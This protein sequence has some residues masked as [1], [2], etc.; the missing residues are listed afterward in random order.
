MPSSDRSQAMAVFFRKTILRVL[1]TCW[2][3]HGSTM[4]ISWW[5]VDLPISDG[6]RNHS[7]PK[8]YFFFSRFRW[9]FLLVS[10]AES[11]S[12]G[13]RAATATALATRARGRWRIRNGSTL[14]AS[15]RAR[16]AASPPAARISGTN[17][18]KELFLGHAKWCA[19]PARRNLRLQCPRPKKSVWPGWNMAMPISRQIEL[20]GSE[21]FSAAPPVSKHEVTRSDRRCHPEKPPLESQNWSTLPFS[22]QIMC[23]CLRIPGGSCRC[24]NGPLPVMNSLLNIESPTIQNHFNRVKNRHVLTGK[25]H[26]FGSFWGSLQFGETCFFLMG[27]PLGFTWFRV[28]LTLRRP[29]RSCQLRA[30]RELRV[31]P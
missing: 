26:H 29:A 3:Q 30:D 25:A 2:A 15:F 4:N 8:P 17:W 27:N 24:S 13:G 20:D 12:L 19:L 11:P 22:R 6:K 10:R 28:F 31:G 14:N 5:D 21:H 7:C 16:A 9:A 18:T 23:D 1:G